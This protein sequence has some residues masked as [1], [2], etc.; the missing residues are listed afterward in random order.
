[1]LEYN[2]IH[3]SIDT[4]WMHTYIPECWA[5]FVPLKAEY[6]KGS[7]LFKIFSNDL[8]QITVNNDLA[9]RLYYAHNLL[10][11]LLLLKDLDGYGIY[12][13]TLNLLT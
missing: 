6:Y 11:L 2:R 3:T 12:L 8:N 9:A 13:I 1:M 7:H 5:A 4:E 10:L